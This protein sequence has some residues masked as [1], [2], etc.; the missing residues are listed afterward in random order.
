[1][2][3]IRDDDACSVRVYIRIYIYIFTWLCI[4]SILDGLCKYTKTITFPPL[5]YNTHT[6]THNAWCI[7][8][9]SDFCSPNVFLTKIK[10]ECHEN[11]IK[12]DE[13]TNFVVY[14]KCNEF[15]FPS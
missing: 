3:F 12:S 8:F 9:N 1:M 10:P 11:T 6:H 13:G 5:R 14:L 15:R 2:R 4:V 7:Y